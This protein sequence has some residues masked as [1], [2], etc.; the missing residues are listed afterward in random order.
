MDTP[1]IILGNGK[2]LANVDL[3]RLSYCHTFGLNGAYLKFTQL[4]WYPTYYG[5]FPKGPEFWNPDDVKTFVMENYLQTDKFF[6]NN[7]DLNRI[8][9]IKTLSR[10]QNI[11]IR[12]P[13]HITFDTRKYTYPFSVEIMFVF[14]EFKK[15][16]NQDSSKIIYQFLHNQKYEDIQKLNFSGIIKKIQNIPLNDNDYIRLPRFKESWF[17]PKNFDNF[18]FNGGVTGTLA[19]LIGYVLG[20]K[21]IILLGMDCTFP[22]TNGIINTTKSHWFENY[23]NNQDYDIK[24]YCSVC[25][26]DSLLKMHLDS[27]QNLKD[28]FEANDKDI[29]I[30]NCTEGSALTCFRNSTLEKEL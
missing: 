30:V 22:T 8:N 20:Y 18:T 3:N 14:D 2:S 13:Q 25:S 24:K 19:A 5:Y 29:E 4:N 21:K 1:L 27:W 15:Q 12:L 23:F 6:F 28:S 9:F 10:I 7:E 17:L 16:P 11:N 26:E